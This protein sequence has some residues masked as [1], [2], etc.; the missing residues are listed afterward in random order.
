[1]SLAEV[2]SNYILQNIGF[3]MSSDDKPFYL[4]THKIPVSSFVL[5]NK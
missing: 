1:M 5:K 2:E 4:A 3:V